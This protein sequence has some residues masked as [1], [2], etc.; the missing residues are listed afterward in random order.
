MDDPTL[1]LASLPGENG[2]PAQRL[3]AELEARLR[4]TSINEVLDE[5]LHAWL[6]DFILLVRQLGQA[7]HSSYLEVA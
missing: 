6:T 7:I 4:Y 5:G 3:A 2:R 1:I